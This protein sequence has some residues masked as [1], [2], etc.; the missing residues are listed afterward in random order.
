MLNLDMKM[1]DMELGHS[2]TNGRS[3][4][5]NCD[6]AST[7]LDFMTVIIGTVQVRILQITLLKFFI[8]L[9]FSDCD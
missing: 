4:G 2:E 6:P 1:D 7:M 9:P 3:A 5:S 8:F